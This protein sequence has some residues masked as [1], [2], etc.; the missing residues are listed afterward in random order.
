MAKSSSAAIKHRQQYFQDK[1]S[2]ARVKGTKAQQPSSRKTNAEQTDETWLCT[3]TH[4][5]A[6]PHK[7]FGRRPNSS[8]TCADTCWSLRTGSRCGCETEMFPASLLVLITARILPE[9]I[10]LE[11]GETKPSCEGYT[12]NLEGKSLTY[13]LVR[14]PRKRLCLS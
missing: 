2:Y 6:S 9:D 8:G 7:V 4:S 13:V 3:G 12:A 14:T 10:F 11:K 5:G 1:N